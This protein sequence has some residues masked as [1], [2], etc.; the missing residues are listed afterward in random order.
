VLDNTPDWY[1]RFRTAASLANDFL[2]DRE[3]QRSRSGP[4]GYS[5]IG[6]ALAQDQAMTD[7]MGP[8]Y[9]R[10]KEHL[11]ASD[12]MI[13][14]SRRRLLAAARK[15]EETGQ[16]PLTVDRPEFYRTRVGSTLLPKG[17]DWLASTR[18]LRAPFVEHR[19]LDWSVTG[20][21]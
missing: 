13:I 3:V 21:M 2:I 11:G 1:G 18:D 19:E 17:A 20:G 7:S 12:T 14:R 5:G 4:N 10:S 15:F 9:D 16:A 8:I 6:S